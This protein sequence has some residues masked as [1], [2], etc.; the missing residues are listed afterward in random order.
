MSNYRRWYVPGGT[1]YF[2]LVTYHRRHLFNSPTARQLLG[3]VMRE[4]RQERPFTQIA[5][6]LLW[7]HLHCIWTLPRGDADY[8]GRWQQIKTE[9]TKRWRRGGGNDRRVTASQARHG[10]RGVWQRRFWEHIVETEEELERICDYIHYN[11]VK[12]RYVAR[13]MDWEWSSFQNFVELGQY[14]EG[15]GRSE[16]ISIKNWDME[17]GE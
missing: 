9:F 2:T 17:L 14:S 8:S 6:V 10:R 3:D 5:F 16:P 12:H 4:I 15:W 1:I 7:D 13:P 11:P